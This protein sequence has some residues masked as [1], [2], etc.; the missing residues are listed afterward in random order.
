MFFFGQS[1]NFVLG[2]PGDFLD[3]RNQFLVCPGA[4]RSAVRH[5]P[6]PTGRC[7]HSPTPLEPTS[8]TSP[9]TSQIAK[10]AKNPRFF[11]K[12]MVFQEN[13][14]F[15]RISLSGWYRGSS[16]LSAAGGMGSVGIGPQGRESVLRHSG[17]VWGI[18][19]IDSGGPESPQVIL[20]RNSVSFQK[21]RFLK[22]CRLV[23]A[24]LKI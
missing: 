22:K 21:V 13:Q 5:S 16:G 1:R 6:C 23:Q 12:I 3:H 2:S 8:R 9:C 17:Q 11:M 14:A 24:D 7:R 19:G 10:F 15:P 18:V 4:A 20:K